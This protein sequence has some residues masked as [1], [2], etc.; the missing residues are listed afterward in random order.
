[1]PRSV[2]AAWSSHPTQTVGRSP[3]WT[4]RSPPISPPRSRVPRGGRRLQA[5]RARKLRAEGREAAAKADFAAALEADDTESVAGMGRRHAAR[6]Q[7]GSDR[8]PRLLSG[9]DWQWQYRDELFDGKVSGRRK[10][11]SPT[12]ARAGRDDAI[13]RRLRS[14]RADDEPHFAEDESA[15]VGLAAYCRGEGVF[16]KELGVNSTLTGWFPEQKL[17]PRWPTPDPSDLIPVTSP[18]QTPSSRQSPSYF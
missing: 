16:S 18:P 12:I 7:R 17:S 14:A 9:R 13:R 5:L 15:G 8:L 10:G 11:S 3:W 4:R 2:S 1:L 6:G